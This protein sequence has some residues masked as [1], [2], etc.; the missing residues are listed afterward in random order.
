MTAIYDI[1]ETLIGEASDPYLMFVLYLVSVLMAFMI[2][3]G[4][5]DM[6]YALI[7]GWWGR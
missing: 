6:M 5:F 3:F 1:M 7:Q 4:I 2:I